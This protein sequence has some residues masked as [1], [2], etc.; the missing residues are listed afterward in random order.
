[1][2]DVTECHTAFARSTNAPRY[3]T[4]TLSQICS[5]TV[6]SLEINIMVMRKFRFRSS[7]RFGICAYIENVQR[8]NR[9]VHHDENWIQQRGA[10]WQG[11]EAVR[12]K[13]HAEIDSIRFP[14]GKYILRT[15]PYRLILGSAYAFQSTWLNQEIRNLQ[16]G[17]KAGIGVLKDHLHAL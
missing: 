8:R 13:V 11:A 12:R 2:L 17:I 9:L 15:D 3:I 10:R 14:K 5:T 4:A 6:I 16:L 1:M 7:I